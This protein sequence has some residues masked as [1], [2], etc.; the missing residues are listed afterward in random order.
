MQSSA[1]KVTIFEVCSLA[2]QL[3]ELA[4]L[5]ME[6]LLLPNVPCASCILCGGCQALDGEV[7]LLVVVATYGWLDFTRIFSLL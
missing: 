4:D 1:C 3:L 6:I 7:V 5:D 2:L